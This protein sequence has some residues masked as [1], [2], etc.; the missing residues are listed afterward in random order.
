M[1]YYIIIY[2]VINITSFLLV[3]SRKDI[4][5]INETKSIMIKKHI[6]NIIKEI[7][8]LKEKTRFIIQK[9]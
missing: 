3:F 2:L 4:L 7:F 9:I 8:Y 5:S 6:I 1:M